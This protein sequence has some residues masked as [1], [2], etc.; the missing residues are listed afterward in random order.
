MTDVLM[1]HNWSSSTASWSMVHGPVLLDQLYIDSWIVVH[2]RTTMYAVHI[3]S[4]S[5]YILPAG[6]TAFFSSFAESGGTYIRMYLR[7]VCSCHIFTVVSKF[8]KLFNG[9]A[10]VVWYSTRISEPL[11]MS[12][13][14]F[15][16]KNRFLLKFVQGHE[17][18]MKH[19]LGLI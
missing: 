9:T 17:A 10:V 16:F 7:S 19:C 5:Q 3:Q 14:G 18:F 13:L 6:T 4:R 1:Q 15:F 2:F 12:F 11:F 8:C